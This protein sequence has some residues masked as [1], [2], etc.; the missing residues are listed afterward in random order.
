M[1]TKEDIKT[2]RDIIK[3]EVEQSQRETFV[4]IENAIL[5]KFDLLAEGHQLLLDTLAPKNRVEALE[6]KV[7]FLEQ[8]IKGLGSRIN[9]LEKKAG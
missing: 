7:E 1:L 3:E 8:I 5:P 2:I 4:Y 6:D 9:E